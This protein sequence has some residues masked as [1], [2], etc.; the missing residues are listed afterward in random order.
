MMV[1]KTGNIFSRT[2]AYAARRQSDAF[3][4][5]C[6]QWVAPGRRRFDLAIRGLL[7]RDTLMGVLPWRVAIALAIGHVSSA[8]AA[9]LAAQWEWV[10]GTVRNSSDSTPI[11]DVV[12]RSIDHWPTFITSSSAAGAFLLRLPAGPVRVLAARIG[13]A[14]ETLTVVPGQAA[15]D[16]RLREVPLALDPIVVSAEPAY[17]AASSRSVRELDIQVRPRETAH[18]L[19]RLAPGLVIAQHAGGGKA[20]QIFLRGFDADH[21][22]DVAVSVDGTPVNMVSHGHGQGYA[23]LHFVIPEVIDLVE[24]R[25]GPYDAQDGDLATAGAVSLRTKDRL[26]GGTA[27]V[28]GGSFNTMHGVVLIPLGANAARAGGYVA[29]SGHFT[30]GPVIAPQDYQ[31]YNLFGKLT[32]PFGPSVEFVA[33]ASGFSSRWD[34]SGQVPERA[35]RQGLISR[36]GSIDPSE[37]GS[38]SR[39]DLSLALRSASGGER[40]WAVR[41]YGTKYDFDLFSNF[42]FFLADSVNGDGINQ[43]DDRVLLGLDANYTLPIRVAGLAGSTSI[44]VGGRADFSDVTLAHAAHRRFLEIRVDA[45]VS[46]QHAFTWLRQDLRVAPSVRLQLGLRGD[47][48]RFEVTDRLAEASPSL[49]HISGGH[50]EAILSPKANLAVEL[51][52]ATTLFANFGRGF[53]SNDARAVVQAGSGTRTL[54]RATGAELGARYVRRGGSVAAA[55]WGLDLQS[56]LVYVGDEGRTEASGPSRRVGVD[57]EMRVQVIPWLWA[58][59]DLSLSRGRFR[60]EPT[61]AN[62]I[63][64]A[65]TFTAL[66]GLTVRDRGPLSGGFRVRYVGARAADETNA[67]RALSHT[68]VG[69]FSRWQVSRF[70]L[71]A[72]VDNLFDVDWNEAQF[73]T[74][75]RLRN[76]SEAVTEL[77]FTP[78]ARRSIQVGVEYRF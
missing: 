23:D 75:S 62:R 49:P 61:G 4:G 25:K 65:P 52:S 74:T 6:I 78:G 39:Y 48:F 8:P 38:T 50:T 60:N 2:L 55:L 64:L 24:V 33:A 9:P 42:T 15:I 68:V 51:S 11:A 47:L 72:S 22:T 59:A 76:E 35:V 27:E 18:E 63:P 12:I 66:A 43:T 36:F 17:T 13:F 19:L 69:L 26:S 73:A 41:A 57:L 1:A 54:P 70:D 20:E 56:E 77:H 44:G 14:P 46:Q 7:R 5:R 3:T 28:R 53:H 32:A 58:D 37:G 21:G 40:S 30:D 31:R 45:R 10:R 71:V 29:A 16:L 34:A 67:V